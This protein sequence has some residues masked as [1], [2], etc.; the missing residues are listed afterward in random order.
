MFATTQCSAGIASTGSVP[1][2]RFGCFESK[3]GQM[4][5]FTGQ[6]A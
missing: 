3:L 4:D 6:H 5:K 1:V 2:V